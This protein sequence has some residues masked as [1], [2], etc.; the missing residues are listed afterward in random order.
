MTDGMLLSE[1]VRQP[2]LSDYGIVILDEAHEWTLHTD[3]LFG[4]LKDL[5]RAR[6]DLKLVIASATL[7]A[8]KFSLYFDEAPV[9]KIPGRKFQ[10]DIYYSKAPEPDYVD[11]AVITVL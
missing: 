7:D 3:I 6:L 11:A 8:E 10:V 1:F 2:D 5:M 9:I 4:L